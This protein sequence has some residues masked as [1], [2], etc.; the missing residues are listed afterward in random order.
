MKIVIFVLNLN[1]TTL[2]WANEICPN[3]SI[4]KI[5]LDRS[6]AIRQ[7]DKKNRYTQGLL[8]KDGYLY[9]STGYWEYS[10]IFVLGP[11]GQESQLA[12]LG[13]KYFGE[14][15]AFLGDKALSIDL[16]IR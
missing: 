13:G 9:E 16:E 10:G 8:V 4:T 5:N 3:D 12:K 14:G 2:A 7:I 1:L 6:M 15:L 11:D